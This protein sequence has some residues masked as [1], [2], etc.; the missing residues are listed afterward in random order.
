M[1]YNALANEIVIQ[2]VKSIRSKDVENFAIINKRTYN[3]S[4]DRLEEL[5]TLRRNAK[6]MTS[7]FASRHPSLGIYGLPSRYVYTSRPDPDEKA[8]R[9]RNRNSTLAGSEYLELNGD[10]HWLQPVSALALKS[11]V[12]YRGEPASKEHLD[13]LVLSAKR[14][15]V[16]IP[17]AFL[18]FIGSKELLERMLLG[19]DWLSLGPSLVK[20]NREDDKEG[21]GYVIRFLRDQQDCRFWF[22]YV[23]PGGYHGVLQ[24]LGDVDVHCWRCSREHPYGYTEYAFDDHPKPKPYEG[25]PVACKRLDVAL[26]SPNFELWLAWRYFD[27][28]RNTVGCFDPVDER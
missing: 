13:K 15:G 21:G 27:G 1:S 12:W 18:T 3:A 5:R 8:D 11:H 14:V 25:A 17:Q 7:R 10:L 22:L 19:G 23:A 4:Y 24:S 9:S 28:C 2:I 16:E 6:T 20:C 26:A